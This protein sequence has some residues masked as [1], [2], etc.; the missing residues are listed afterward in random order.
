MNGKSRM[1]SHGPAR[2]NYLRAAG[3]EPPGLP[4]SLDELQVFV[5]SSQLRVNTLHPPRRI[6][7]RHCPTSDYL[8][9]FTVRGW[10]TSTS[11]SCGSRSC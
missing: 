9:S 7:Q 8:D 11:S 5:G 3:R 6:R 1:E 10:E 4:E 2:A